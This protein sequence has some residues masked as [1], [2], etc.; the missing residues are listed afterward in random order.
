V[1]DSVN[2]FLPAPLYKTEINGVKVA[3]PD[4]V[5]DDPE[6]SPD[7]MVNYVFA[8]IGGTEILSASRSDLINSP[9]NNGYTV[10]V[11]AGKTF[12]KRQSIIFTEVSENIFNSFGINANEFLLQDAAQ[13]VTSDPDTGIITISLNGVKSRYFIDVEIINNVQEINGTI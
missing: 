2:A 13:V 7:T 6:L 4:I 9:L 1:V 8:A 5:L 12:R 3:T 10:L 11:D